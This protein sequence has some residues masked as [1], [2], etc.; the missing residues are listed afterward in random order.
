MSVEL[1]ELHHYKTIS[2]VY[3]IIFVLGFICNTIVIIVFLGTRSLRQNSANYLLVSMTASDWMMAALSSSVGA[4]ANSKY[5]WNLHPGFCQYFGFI[6]SMVG[7]SS[8]VHITALAVEKWFTLKMARN[9]EIGKGKMLAIVA[10]LWFFAFLWALF[11]LVGWSFYAPEPGYAGCSV[12]WYANTAANNAFIICLFI[13]FFFIPIC[14]VIFCFSSIYLEVR[15]LAIGAV[16]RWGQ[17]SGSTQETVRAKAKTIRMSL[18]MVLAFIIAWAPYAVV[19]LHSSFIAN[20]L[21]PALTTLPAMFA[22]LS[23]FYN[24]IIYFFMYTKFRNAAKRMFIKKSIWP[25]QTTGSATSQSQNGSFMTSFPRPAQFF[26]RMSSR[27]K[28]AQS[29]TTGQQ[30]IDKTNGQSISDDYVIQR[31]TI[32]APAITPASL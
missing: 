16:Q 2:A 28:S 11:P 10:S 32:P 17:S 3:S 26:E 30:S 5:W 25:Q 9:E 15:K 24:P 29:I 27:H 23:T 7:Y 6:S 14:V 20:D 18:V 19:S 21:P 4:Y 31:L 22:K 8:M 1:F 12:A 13:F